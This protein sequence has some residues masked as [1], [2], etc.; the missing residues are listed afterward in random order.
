M[1]LLSVSAL[2][3]VAGW[4]PR[5]G[6]GVTAVGAGDAEGCCAG[7]CLCGSD[8]SVDC[9][10]LGL[11]RVPCTIPLNATR[12]LI[13][14]NRIVRLSGSDLGTR[15]LGNVTEFDASSMHL[16]ELRADALRG[17]LL[18]KAMSKEPAH[19]TSRFG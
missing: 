13:T 9:S 1:W 15:I 3:L 6:A 17:R 19:I 10:N 4:G 11:T 18:S 14:G 16:A 2:L 7:V 5:P 8:G 12:L